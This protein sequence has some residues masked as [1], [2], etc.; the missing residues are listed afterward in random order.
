MLTLYTFALSTFSEKVRWALDRGGATYREI[1]LLPGPHIAVVRR[2]APR[3]NV[4]VLVAGNTVIQESAA[5]L[6]RL[7]TLGIQHD[8]S[9]PAPALEQEIDTSIG[10][11]LQTILYADALQQRG[12]VKRLWLQDGPSWGPAFYALAYPWVARQVRAMYCS[13]PERLKQAREAFER[14]CGRLDA[15][16]SQTPYL[17][18]QQPSRAD[19]ALAALAAP[20]VQ[21]STHPFAWPEPTPEIGRWLEQYRNRPTLKHVERLYL[22]LRRGKFGG[23]GAGAQ[24]AA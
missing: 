18:G 17:G 8:F 4:P 7:Q 14:V 5:I 19:L 15:A 6:D 13:P 20:L 21:P 24:S 22:T 10:A 11:A 12:L 23:A 16:L 1:K 2:I 3:N 9:T